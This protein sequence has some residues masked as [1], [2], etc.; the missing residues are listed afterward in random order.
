MVLYEVISDRARGKVGTYDPYEPRFFLSKRLS[1]LG[2]HLVLPTQHTDSIFDFVS[3]GC[4]VVGHEG[5]FYFQ[6]EIVIP[7][8]PPW[9]YT[10]GC[11]GLV[12]QEIV[13]TSFFVFWSEVV[14]E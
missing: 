7:D 1:K 2:S 3:L 10:E 14:G 8:I 13:S 5:G 4:P 9:I 11:N 6:I 12:D